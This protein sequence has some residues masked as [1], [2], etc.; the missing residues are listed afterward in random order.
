VELRQIDQTEPAAIAETILPRRSMRP[1]W[2]P[3]GEA[4]SPGK[5]LA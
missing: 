5:Q 4:V 3:A 2:W 1:C